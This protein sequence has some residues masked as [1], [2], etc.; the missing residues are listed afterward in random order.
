MKIYLYQD[1]NNDVTLEYRYC[2][3]CIHENNKNNEYPCNRCNDFQM[4]EGVVE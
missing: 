2:L 3:T 1:T 4:W